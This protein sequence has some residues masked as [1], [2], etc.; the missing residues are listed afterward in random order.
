MSQLNRTGIG[1]LI[2]C[3]NYSSRARPLCVTAYVLLRA[4]SLFK[5]KRALYYPRIPTAHELEAV[6][7]CWIVHLQDEL[8]QQKNFS[9]LKQQFGLFVDEEKLWR[10]GGR[11]H[12]VNIPYAVKYP[13]LLPRRHPFTL[14]IVRDAHRRVLHKWG[15]GDAE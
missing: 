14:L 12:N 5:S 10:C 9:D 4:V 2:A 3:E 11:F 6:E 1:G 7:K 15:Q 8:V 13:I